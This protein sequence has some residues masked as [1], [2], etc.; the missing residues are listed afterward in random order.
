MRLDEPSD[1]VLATRL[2]P[3]ED[4]AVELS[5]GRRALT[6]CYLDGVLAQEVIGVLEMYLRRQQA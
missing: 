3:C 4:T 1:R 2:S 5:C 6:H